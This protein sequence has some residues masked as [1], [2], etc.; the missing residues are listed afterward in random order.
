M[1]DLAIGILQYATHAVFLHGVRTTN[2]G[3]LHQLAFMAEATMISVCWTG[4]S[5]VG[6]VKTFKFVELAAGHMLAITNLAVCVNLALVI[7]V[8]EHQMMGLVRAGDKM[9]VSIPS[10]F[11]STRLL[12]MRLRLGH[13]DIV[14][15]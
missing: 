13:T 15:L 10:A 14:T 2:S 7:M 8:S 11:F 12:C 6:L 9:F 3:L 1:C 5:L 4:E